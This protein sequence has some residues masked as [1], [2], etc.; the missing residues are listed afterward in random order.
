MSLYWRQRLRYCLKSTEVIGGIKM[1]VK[2][3]NVIGT[4]VYLH[5]EDANHLKLRGVYPYIGNTDG[6]SVVAYYRCTTG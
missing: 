4:T 1:W 2:R 3:D 5:P 6:D